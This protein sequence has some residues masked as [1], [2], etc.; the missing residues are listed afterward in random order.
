MIKRIV[1]TL[2]QFIVFLA[3]I[4]VGGNWDAVNLA[5]EMHALQQHKTASL[6]V[7]VFKYPM[8]SHIL[9]ANGLIFATVLLLL[10]LLFL[11]L[12]KKLHPW[13]LLS[14]LAFALAVCLGFAMK[15][16]LPPADSPEQ[17]LLSPQLLTP[18]DA[19]LVDSN[20]IHM[21]HAIARS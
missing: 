12:R 4:A 7:P 18:E 14:L 11:L 8:G 21:P 10:I 3:L 1:L 5:V 13:A 6:L 9:I 15:L 19:A 17:T 16:G 20:P 2:L